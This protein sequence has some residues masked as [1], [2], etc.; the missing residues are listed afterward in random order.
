MPNLSTLS[1]GTQILAAAGVLL[2]IDT[3]L[4]WQSIDVGPF[5]AGKNAWSGFWGVIMGL[6][7]LVLL[8]WV[9]A[10][11]FDVKLPTELPEG[12]IIL[13]LGA[14]IFVF[15]LL[16]NLIDDYSTIWSYIGVLLAAGVAYGA[17]LR[18]Q[19][20]V[21]VVESQTPSTSPAAPSEPATPTPPPPS[22]T[23]DD[24]EARGTSEPTGA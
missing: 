16:K 4:D 20:T 10:R 18:N 17:W 23:P 2:L 24:D 6:A 8:A 14:L 9:I 19:E 1:R 7:L 21:G 12:S 13:G 3:F 15:A 11:I 5:S 22:V